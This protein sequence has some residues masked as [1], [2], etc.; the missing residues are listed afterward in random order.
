[1]DIKTRPLSAY[2]GGRGVLAHGIS[3]MPPQLQS[4]CVNRTLFYPGCFNPPHTGH[5]ALLR[6][7]LDRSGADLNIIA[8]VVFP[9]SDAALARKLGPNND[10]IKFGKEERVRLWEGYGP[11]G[12]FWIFGHSD[13]DWELFQHNLLRDTARDGFEVRISLLYGPDHLQE[14]ETLPIEPWG[15]KEIF[16]SDIGRDTLITSSG[17]MLLKQLDLYS[18]WKRCTVDCEAARKAAEAAASWMISGFFMI[19]PQS[20]STMLEKSR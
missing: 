13:N 8:G 15:C 18:P 20:G 12:D 6:H 7:V 2:I 14:M 5:L 11:A 16:F 4:N 3:Y 17:H 1:M 9:L 19:G 10:E